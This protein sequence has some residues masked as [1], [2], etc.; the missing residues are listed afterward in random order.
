MK[1][2]SNENL[3]E[4]LTKQELKFLITEVKETLSKD[5]KKERKSKFTA[6]DLWNIQR[7][8]KSRLIKRISY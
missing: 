2:Q 1:L 8:K 7:R 4:S 3:L 6:A 5:F